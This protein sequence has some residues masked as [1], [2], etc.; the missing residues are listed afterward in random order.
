MGSS[1]AESGEAEQFARKAPMTRVLFGTGGIRGVANQHPITP[2]LCLRLGRAVVQ[3]LC[4]A[5]GRRQVVIGNDTRLSG[6]MLESALQAGIVSAGGNVLLV[7]SLPTP[8]IAFLTRSLRADVGI[9]VSASHNPYQDN[10]LK[11]FGRDGA[12]IDAQL[13][14]ELERLLAEDTGL[15]GAAEL[16]RAVR[17]TDGPGRYVQYLKDSFPRHLSLEGLRLVVD[18]AHGAA[19]QVAPQVF[20]ELGAEVVPLGVDPNG[21][22]INDGCGALAPQVVAAAVRRH[23]AALGVSF[24]GDADRVILCDE[25]GEVVDGD[26]M[27]AII[28][29]RLLAR[30]V[31]PGRTVVG[32]VMSNLG[33]ERHLD[34]HGATLLRTPVGVS[35]VIRAMSAGGYTLGGEPS[36][37]LVFLDQASTDD[38]ILS[39]LGVLAVVTAEGRS[40]SQLAGAMTRYPQVLINVEVADR[41]PLEQMPGVQSAIAGAEQSLGR[42]GR[43]LV[44]YS[45]T[46]SKLRI[47]VE[48]RDAGTARARA[49]EIAEAVRCGAR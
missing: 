8:A 35:Q 36:G 43:V 11:L 9:V 5:A 28:A 10:G 16:G 2:E 31:L 15:A 12:L 29:Q 7:G 44:R 30:Q 27:L 24:D 22:N 38:G 33:L 45:G 3:R 1:I 23:Q 48:G 17:V 32:T 14:G 47:M 19:Y 34:A 39:A 18:C 6:S 13:E 40:L 46:E 4:R 41:H 49:E 25:R 21:R 20:S 26:Q 42:D 37:H